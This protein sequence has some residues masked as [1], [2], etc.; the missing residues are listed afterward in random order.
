MPDSPRCGHCVKL[1]PIYTE[2]A[3]QLKQAGS[4]IKLAK[5]DV[6]AYR[7]VG[8]KYGV[9]SFPTMKLFLGGRDDNPIEFKGDRKPSFIIRWLM[10]RTSDSPAVKASTVDQ[11][12][13]M[14]QTNEL[15]AIGMFKVSSAKLWLILS[16]PTSFIS[17]CHIYHLCHSTK[18][19]PFGRYL[20]S[21]PGRIRGRTGGNENEQAEKKRPA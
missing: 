8:D 18:R 19:L 11:I 15:I 16:A 21:Y 20:L 2:C 5:L 17:C 6:P 4:T 3:R 1:T 14:A 12:L 9:R 13:S 7:E 10:K